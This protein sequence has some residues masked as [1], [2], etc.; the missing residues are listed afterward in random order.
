M[1]RFKTPTTDD[2]MAVISQ[3][4]VPRNT[5]KN[6]EWA[7]RVFLEWRAARNKSDPSNHCPEDLLQK[8]DV[9]KLNYWLCRFVTEV[10]KKDGQPYPPKTIQQILAALQR[11]MLDINPDAVKFLDSSQSAFVS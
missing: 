3:G 11:K 2:E 5:Q 8:P 7:V 4:Y 9:Q 10:R 1:S 6:T